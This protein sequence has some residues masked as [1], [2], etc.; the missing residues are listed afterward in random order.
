M[1]K[2]S[3]LAVAFVAVVAV[4][5]AA[6]LDTNIVGKWN[7]SIQV[8][9]SKIPPMT[10]PAMKKKVDE[11]LAKLKKAKI[12][13]MIKKDHTY[14]T[15]STGMPNMAGGPDKNTVSEGTWKQDGKVVTL[16]TTKEDG[17]PAKNAGDSQAFTISKDGKSMSANLPGA[18]VVL[19]R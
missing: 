13:V 16:T 6:N 5:L 3:A 15:K 8:D 19:K 4:S 12:V 10:D 9:T 11:T 7:G 17:K 14:T 1:R 2:I 18:T